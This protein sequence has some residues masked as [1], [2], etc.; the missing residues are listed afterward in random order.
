MLLGRQAPS[1]SRWCWAFPPPIYS[2]T[3]Q[4]SRWL[5]FCLC[6]DIM[7][8][9]WNGC[10]RSVTLRRTCT[11]V[12]RYV[13][14]LSIKI[15]KL[16]WNTPGVGWRWLEQWHPRLLH[17]WMRVRSLGNNRKYHLIGRSENTINYPL[18]GRHNGIRLLLRFAIHIR[19]DSH[20]L[21]PYLAYTQ[22][23]KMIDKLVCFRYS[24]AHWEQFC[25]FFVLLSLSL[26]VV[27]RRCPISAVAVWTAASIVAASTVA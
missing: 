8:N 22:R 3:K 13:Y 20:S 6:I 25:F 9:A 4:A 18:W 2:S 7:Q 26:L 11:N 21:P 15:N 12:R 17:E 19:Y 10:H 16:K 24:S 1:I 23:Q 14:C 27:C 5:S